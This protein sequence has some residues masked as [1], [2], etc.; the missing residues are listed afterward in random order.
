MTVSM[1][2]GSVATWSA[3]LAARSADCTLPA[4]GGRAEA[5]VGGDAV[6]EEH[7]LLAHEG[8]LLAQRRQRPVGERHAVERHAPGGRVEKAR[9]QVHQRG[10]AG[11]RGADEGDRLAGADVEIDR[12]ERGARHSRG[13]RGGTDGRC[14]GGL[15]GG[16]LGRME[17]HRHGTQRELAA[18][19]ARC[20]R[21]PGLARRVLDQVHAALDRGQAARD[22]PHHVAQAPQRRRDRDGRGDEGDEL[23]GRHAAVLALPERHA[24]HRGECAGGDELRDRRDHRAGDG[25]LEQQPPQRAARGV[26]AAALG[27][28]RAVQA[29]QAPGEHVLFD[30][31]GEGVDRHLRLARDAV[32]ALAEE[33][34]READHRRHRGDEER[35][36]PVEPD[37]RYNMYAIKIDLEYTTLNMLKLFSKFI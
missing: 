22:R 17:P 23:A 21:A 30:H 1:P 33:P 31:V 2:F 20:M 32:H 19:S 13:G 25:R 27:R 26:E 3:R 29:H 18:G 9:Q 10:L 24:D 16:G 14:A 37:E 12:L 15:G 7:H 36:L 28:L 8:E 34:H 11:P 6:V 5:D 4:T 35:E